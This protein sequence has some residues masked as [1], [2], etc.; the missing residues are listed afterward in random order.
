VVGC[1]T[2]S[3]ASFADVDGNVATE[4]R[5]ARAVDDAHPARAKRRSDGDEAVSK[6]ASGMPYA[7]IACWNARPAGLAVR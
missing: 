7:N 3:T 2:Q 1:P 4:A 5:I 6:A